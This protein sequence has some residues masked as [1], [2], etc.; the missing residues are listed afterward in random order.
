MNLLLYEVMAYL[1]LSKRNH[2]KETNVQEMNFE[3]KWVH[4][5]HPITACNP[6]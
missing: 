6:I 3:R 2:D 1:K 5:R 4:V